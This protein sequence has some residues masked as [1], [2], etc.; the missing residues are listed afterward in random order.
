MTSEVE[1]YNPDNDTIGEPNKAIPIQNLK[2]AICAN[3]SRPIMEIPTD[4]GVW[5]HGH[6][7][8]PKCNAP[9]PGQE[10]IDAARR[11]INDG[12]AEEGIAEAFGGTSNDD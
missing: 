9:S 10:A 1:E 5:S 7:G 12:V 8:S 3:C 2:M 11:I 6:N 4:P